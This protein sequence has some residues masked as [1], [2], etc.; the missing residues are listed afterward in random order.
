MAPISLEQ[1]N[2]LYPNGF[3][4]VHD[5]DLD[6][7][8]GELMVLVGPSGMWQDHGASDGRRPRGHHDWHAP[9]RLIGSSTTSRHASATWRWCSRAM[10][11]T[12]T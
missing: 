12:H 7:A 4:A 11:S 9:L 2:K 10:P 6:V 3:H 8:E 5:F 1:V